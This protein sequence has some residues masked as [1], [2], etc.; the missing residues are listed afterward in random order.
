VSFF[1]RLRDHCRGCMRSHQER[2]TLY[3]PAKRARVSHRTVAN[4][5]TWRPAARRASVLRYWAEGRAS[6]PY[7]TGSTSSPSRFELASRTVFSRAGMVTENR[8]ASGS[9]RRPLGNQGNGR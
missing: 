7:A 3:L 4:C 9:L 8:A 1:L 6:N 5:W 2:P